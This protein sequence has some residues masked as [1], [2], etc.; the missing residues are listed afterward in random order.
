MA[1]ELRQ[2][3]VL[4]VEGKD[5]EHFFAGLFSQAG[6]AGIQLLPIGGK[7]QLQTNLKALK[8]TPNFYRVTSLGIARDANGDPRA[9]F[10][11]VCQSLANAGFPVPSQ[12]GTKSNPAPTVSVFILP[13]GSSKGMLEDLCL[14]AVSGS[15]LLACVDQFLLCAEERAHVTPNNKAK[16]RAHAFLAAQVEPGKRVGEAAEASFWP[17]G[18]SAFDSLRAFLRSL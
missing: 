15:P 8:L 5:E 9:A 10:Q 4:L 14:S 16:A 18:H 2:N 12:V 6:I 7:T 17:L 3:K 13:D 11:S 1:I